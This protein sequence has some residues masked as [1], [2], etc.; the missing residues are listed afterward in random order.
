M[1][2]FCFVLHNFSSVSKNVFRFHSTKNKNNNR[3]YY[4]II[5]VIIQVRKVKKFQPLHFKEKSQFQNSVVTIA[6]SL[7]GLI[8]FLIFFPQISDN[9]TIWNIN[10]NCSI[11]SDKNSCGCGIATFASLPHSSPFT[12]CHGK[13]KRQ[14]NLKRTRYRFTMTGTRCL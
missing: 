12:P 2:L 14:T 9:F 11:I 8:E 10:R 4:L 13:V 6:P 5:K 7:R 3:W 1:V